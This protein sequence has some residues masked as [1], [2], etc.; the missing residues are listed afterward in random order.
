[1]KTLRKFIS[2]TV[3]SGLISVG[4]A[5][6]AHAD[7]LVPAATE[8]AATVTVDAVITDLLDGG[9]LY[10]YD[11]LDGS[12]M[13]VPY[14]P[15]D[16]DPLTA[17]D[18]QLARYDVDPR[19]NSPIEIS[20]W[21]KVHAA[22]VRPDRPQESI[23]VP[24]V[25]SQAGTIYTSIWGGWMVGNM[26]MTV[27]TYVGVK[28]TFIV[29]SL[30]LACTG[31]NA[32]AV[33]VGLG[34]ASGLPNELVQQGVTQCNFHIGSTY[35]DGWVPFYEYANTLDPKPLCM[36]KTPIPVGHRVYQ[37]LTFLTGVNIGYF[38]LDDLD[39]TKGPLSCHSTAPGGWQFNG[40]TAEWIVEKPSLVLD[41]YNFVEWT[42]VQVQAY[43][44]LNY[45]S[46]ASQPHIKVQTGSSSLLCQNTENVSNN[47]S[48]MTVWY[49][50]TC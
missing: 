36:V 38:Y 45:Y 27:N 5:T 46:I 19:P 40:A 33:W 11:L 42:G 24:S 37:S 47:S 2:I 9:Q 12:V 15:A 25:M 44:D 49:A 22:Y 4:A 1:M 48:F 29:P 32:S 16:F 34:G 31:I 26:Y 21:I 50:S 17:S 14:P 41:N 10:T 39:D 28:G 6:S 43:S 8:T 13:T 18:E 30:S 23:E 3:V 7:T 35:W 20:D